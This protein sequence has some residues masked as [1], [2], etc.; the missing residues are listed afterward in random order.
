MLGVTHIACQSLLQYC[1]RSV[2]LLKLEAATR[3]YNPDGGNGLRMFLQGLAEVVHSQRIL[4]LRVRYYALKVRSL[5]E[6]RTS[7]KR[8]DRSCGFYFMPHQSDKSPEKELLLCCVCAVVHSFKIDLS[9]L[10]LTCR[11]GIMGKSLPSSLQQKL[12]NFMTSHLVL[13][14]K[15][16]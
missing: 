11:Y 10:D 8:N 7:R 2:E 4:L 15:N 9:S 3:D 6:L 14:H 5:S 13:S 16:P 12:N 1:P